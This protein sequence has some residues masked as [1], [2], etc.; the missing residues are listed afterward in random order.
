M[1]NLLAEIC[2]WLH[3]WFVVPGGI[4]IDTY[5]VETDSLA[6][7]FLKDGQYYRVI[8]SVYNDGIHQYG[9]NDLYTETFYGAVWALALPPALIS[10]A[11]EIE[12]WNADNA[13]A[14]SSPYQSESFGGYSY[15]MA[16][17][18]DNNG[19]KTTWRDVFGARLVQWRKL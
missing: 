6:L 11:G 12:K 10:I 13:A 5:T 18:S 15:T 4:H 16:G 14:L 7:P 19:G 2:S 17:R 8:G 9:E 3:N 1:N